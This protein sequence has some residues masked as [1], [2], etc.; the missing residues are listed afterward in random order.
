MKEIVQ[1]LVKLPPD[2]VCLLST[3]NMCSQLNQEM[4]KTLDGEEIQLIALDTVNYPVNLKSKVGK[5]LLKYN[6]DSVAW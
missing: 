3:R 2:T 6:D 5:L 4:L 1:K